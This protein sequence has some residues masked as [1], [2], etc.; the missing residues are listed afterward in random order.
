MEGKALHYQSA[1]AVKG[2]VDGA[3]QEVAQLQAIY[4]LSDALNRA[5]AVEAIY[6]EA[7]NGLQRALNV[8]RA[9]ILILD[10]EGV[11][12]FK[13]WRNLSETYRLTVEGHSPWSPQA[14]SPEPILISDALAELS[15]SPFAQ[16]IGAEGIRAMAFIPLLDQGRLLG[17]FMVYYCTPHRFTDEEV[18][19]LR[20][21]ASHIAFAI[22]RKWSEDALRDR[23][24]WFKE[25]FEG[26]RDAIFLVDSN[27]WLIGVNQAACDLTG[28]SRDELVL[29]TLLELYDEDLAAFRS[30]FYSIV[31]GIEDVSE[32][33]I[34]RRD[35]SRVAV[36]CSH[37]RTVIRG[38]QLIHITV[39][40]ITERK[41]AEE[42]LRASEARYRL[43]FERNMAGVYL[44]T[45]DGRLLDLNHSMAWIL[46]YAT[47]A[48]VLARGAV[49][50]YFEPS[51][52]QAF[53]AKLE[54]QKSLIN[55]ETCLRRK[56]GGPVWVIQNG[57]LIPA[58]N[59]VPGAVQV[60]AI[61][62][63][64]RRQAEAK[65]THSRE[66]LRALA[67]H[68]QSVREEER[69][70]IAREIHDEL[71]QT[72]TGL[73]LDLA[74]VGHRLR[75]NQ[76]Q[77]QQKTQAMLSTLENTMNSVRR[78]TQELRPG[79]LDDLGLGAAI[80]WQT[81]DFQTRTGISC[82]FASRLETIALDQARSTAVFRIFQ[83]TLTNIARHSEARKVKISLKEKAGIFI[84][85]VRD[86]GRGIQECE[87]STPR[88]LGLLGMRERAIL[89]GGELTIQ[90]TPGKGT[91]VTLRIPIGGRHG[92]NSHCR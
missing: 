55:H 12:R 84:L 5:E 21:I 1:S 81:Q 11:M 8:D 68:L 92:A 30:R 77:L 87:V 76:L 23:E 74:W 15:L 61:D 79:I 9:S 46:G 3:S 29:K 41:H 59:G 66:Q 52:R 2:T 89:L 50:L 47:P 27:A 43:L 36:E 73:K 57:S 64:E 85:E 19:L 6:D 37:R 14:E 4:Q 72:L 40:D 17:K 34:R 86:N 49:D 10:S 70:R 65:I 48:E 58:V 78:I 35:G 88:S 18:R 20:L 44:T 24:E 32:A 13:A 33:L 75:A 28:H 83:E 38:R 54:A 71:G 90:G 53:M 67:G 31:S 51:E 62:I 56:D 7:L 82:T 26:S 45:L 25:I 63:T 42:A 60:T 22:T 39:R 69:G 91:V 80:E 16:V